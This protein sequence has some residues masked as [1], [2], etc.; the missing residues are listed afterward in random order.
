MARAEGSGYRF[1]AEYLEHVSRSSTPSEPSGDDEHGA[2][3]EDAKVFRSFVRNGRITSLPASR[4][5]RLVLLDWLAQRFV[6]GQ[7]YPEREVN[8]ILGAVHPD[9][10]ALRRYL[11]DEGLLARHAG[12]YWRVG[13]TF[14][15]E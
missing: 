11:V 7:R 2:S 8:R 1:V 13:G 3:P 12:E 6:P 15:V 10:A 5:K 4:A 14:D 9:V